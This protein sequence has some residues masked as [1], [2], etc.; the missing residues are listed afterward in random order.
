MPS[1]NQNSVLAYRPLKGGIAVQNPV[2]GQIGTIGL[3]ATSD[4]NDRW[5]VSCYHVLC[6]LNGTFPKDNQEPIYQPFCSPG[7]NPVAEVNAN[8]SKE[9]FDCAAARIKVVASVGQIFGIGRLRQPVNPV[10]GMWVI[11]SGADTGITEGRITA[12]TGDKVEIRA[13]GTSPQYQLSGP[14]DSGAAWVDAATLSPVALHTGGDSFQ[15]GVVAF[16]VSMPFVL[17]ALG[18]KMAID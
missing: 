17:Q 11:K 9:E 4:D 2:V 16:G 5:I 10:V 7:D 1:N 18:L 3:I 15:P 8:S 12:V 6:R 13:E 14:G